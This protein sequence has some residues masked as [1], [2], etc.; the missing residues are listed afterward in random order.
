MA[1]PRAE[2]YNDK[3]EAIL[4]R[5]A[6]LFAE[7]GYDRT[8]MAEIA[9]VCGTSKALLYHYYE[10]KEQLLFDVIHN[11]INAL[12]EACRAADDL[13]L[14]PER[15]LRVLVGAL[16]DAY[17]DADAEHKVQLNDL[18]LLPAA[19]QEQIRALERQLVA[20]FASVIGAINP[21]LFDCQGRLLKPVTMSLFGMLNWHYMW[22]RPGGP[23]TREDY[24]EVATRIIVSGAR[25]V[26]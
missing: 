15:R 9:R 1:R 19:K 26:A 7:R 14:P 24:A 2:D 23:L 12:C 4:D 13:A 25:E 20:L 10:S 17:R 22:F 18:A 21:R 8:S 11:H 5:T 6:E 16:L 3:R